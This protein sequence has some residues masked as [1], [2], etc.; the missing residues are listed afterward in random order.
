MESLPLPSFYFGLRMSFV[1]LGKSTRLTKLPVLLVINH[2]TTAVY[3]QVSFL[4]PKQSQ[5]G[6]SVP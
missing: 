2:Q 1:W 5:Q 3:L 6:G 4:H